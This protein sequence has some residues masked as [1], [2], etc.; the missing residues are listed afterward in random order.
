[1]ECC[2]WWHILPAA[3]RSSVTETA[4]CSARS[5][6]RSRRAHPASRPPPPS[7]PRV[8]GPL[9]HR[10]SAP[11]ATR[12]SFARWMPGRAACRPRPL[13]PWL[14]PLSRCHHDRPLLPRPSSRCCSLSAASGTRER[15]RVRRGRGGVESLVVALCVRR[16]VPRR[17]GDPLLDSRCLRP[18][19]V[20]GAGVCIMSIIIFPPPSSVFS[21]PVFGPQ[22]PAFFFSRSVVLK[23][24]SV[25]MGP[26]S[27][28]PYLYISIEIY[29]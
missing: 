3:S 6:S 1:M 20:S 2:I 18:P 10:L 14:T 25:Y 22:P 13:H 26:I 8:S 5:C 12:A 11:P 16:P 15:V 28:S 23:C 4:S 19:S 17:C 7:A 9:G 27:M 29:G 21:Q 24:V